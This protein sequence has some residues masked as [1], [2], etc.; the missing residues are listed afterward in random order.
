MPGCPEP[1]GKLMYCC[2]K[3]DREGQVISRNRHGFVLPSMNVSWVGANGTLD[4]K[5]H[6]TLRFRVQ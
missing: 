5:G 2:R 3:V 4:E 1:F 6:R